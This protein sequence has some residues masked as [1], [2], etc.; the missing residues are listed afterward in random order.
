MLIVKNRQAHSQTPSKPDDG[1][2][3]AETHFVCRL[4][5]SLYKLAFPSY[6][7]PH[8]CMHF[9][10]DC[11]RSWWCGIIYLTLGTDLNIIPNLTYLYDKAHANCHALS[12]DMLLA[13]KWGASTPATNCTFG[14]SWRT[15]WHVPRVGAI[16]G[17]C[18]TQFMPVLVS[19]F[20]GGV[21]RV[22]AGA[23]HVGASCM[24]N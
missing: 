12:T 24:S 2:V 8:A 3:L 13:P 21:K 6:T 18:N 15:L 20:E 4:H 11:S 10:M 16:H 17:V 1:L 22:W 14:W 7:W 9:A 23:S 19:H 5:W